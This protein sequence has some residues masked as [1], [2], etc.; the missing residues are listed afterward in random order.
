M[1]IVSR[2]HSF[3]AGHRV[4]GHPNKCN[5]THGHNY[6]IEVNFKYQEISDLGYRVDFGE[7]K[8][9]FIAW[10][11]MYIDHGYIANP[12]DPI[13]KYLEEQNHKIHI[14]HLGNPTAENIATELYYVAELMM[15]SKGL[16][17]DNIKLWETPNC[18][19]IVDRIS[20]EDRYILDTK[21]YPEYKSSLDTK[22]FLQC[23]KR[24]E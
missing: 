11:E 20:P 16:T 18:Y 8:S 2:V 7:I 5:N 6:K 12:E 4:I 22:N 17:V 19:V 3:C 21:F 9:I 1:G 23:K 10:I 13:I 24:E 14:M 15:K